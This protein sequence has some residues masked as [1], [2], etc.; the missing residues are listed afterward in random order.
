[1]NLDMTYKG[2][3]DIMRMLEDGSIAHDAI[4]E[5]DSL[6]TSLGETQRRV[7]RQKSIACSLIVFG[8][9]QSLARQAKL[10]GLAGANI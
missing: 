3:L 2:S 10:A 9:K 1:M 5:A 7:R 8:V 4:W 6:W